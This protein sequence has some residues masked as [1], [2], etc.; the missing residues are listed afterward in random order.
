MMKVTTQDDLMAWLDRFASAP[1]KGRTLIAP[2][3]VEEQILYR[4]VADSSEIAAFQPNFINTDLSV[5]EY[6]LPFTHPLFSIVRSSVCDTNPSAS[7]VS[8]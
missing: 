2:K 3:V 1:D 8:R 5:K 7:K 6:F 4:P